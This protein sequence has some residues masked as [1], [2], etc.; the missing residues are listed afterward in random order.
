MIRQLEKRVSEL[1]SLINKLA[2]DRKLTNGDADKGVEAPVEERKVETPPPPAVTPATVKEEDEWAEPE[3]KKEPAKGRDEDA[4][5]RISGLETW[6]KKQSAEEAKRE[7]ELRDKTKFTLS[8]KYKLRLNIK[9]NINLNT[10]KQE[11][12]YDDTAYFDQRFQLKLEAEHGPLSGVVV[13][14]KGNFVF[15]WK[16][17]S[18][19]TLDRWSEFHTVN[20]ALI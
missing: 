11:W 8:G 1:E 12:T 2:E 13:F 17:D 3:V 20:A 15:D 10:P 4:R 7:E 5:R 14:D 19:G 16:E 9:D 6:Q 18:E